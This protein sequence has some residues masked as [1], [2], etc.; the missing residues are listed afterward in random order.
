MFLVG[1]GI[2]TH[3]LP[4]A[5]DSIHH[6]VEAAGHTP[7]VGAPLAAL[8]PAL[9]DLIL[10]IIAGSLILAVV[11]LTHRLRKMRASA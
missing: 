2:L 9:L 1:G 3:G 7:M 8:L 11:S 4:F 10:G 6:F 5:H